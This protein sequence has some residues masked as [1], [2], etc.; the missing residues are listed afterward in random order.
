MAPRATIGAPNR[1]DGGLPAT[2]NKSGDMSDTLAALLFDVDGTLADTE[3]SGHLPAF[4]AAFSAAGL[5]W[6]WSPQMYGE[7]LR[8]TGGK[9]RIRHYLRE[10]RPD[11]GVAGADALIARLHQDKNRIYAE[12]VATGEVPLRPGVR[13]LLLQA[14]TEGLSLAIAT[15]TSMENVVA[16]LEHCLGPGAQS[17]FEAIVAGDMVPAKKPAPDA[18]FHALEALRLRADQ[19]LAVEDSGNGL[20]AALAARVPTLVTVSEYSAQD[21]FTGAAAVLDHLGEPDLQVRVLAGDLGDATYVDV[22]VLRELH[23]RPARRG[24]R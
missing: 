10:Y 21:D 19:C 2:L 9:E 3:S 1:Y 5:D 20:R 13:R 22:A 24:P 18:Y 11:V 12:A 6:H 15:T 23:A 16:L 4:N 17:W 7:L 8:V 14:R